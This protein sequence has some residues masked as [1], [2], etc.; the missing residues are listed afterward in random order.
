M[1][2]GTLVVP[3]PEAPRM[4]GL[5]HL[6]D[7]LLAEVRDRIQLT[8]GLRHEVADRLNSGP[9]EAVVGPDAELELLDQ[10]VVH[11]IGRPRGRTNVIATDEPGLGHA[12]SAR[13][14]ELDD[15]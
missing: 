13:L 12:R 9:F 1:T 2:D 7:R 3:E 10:D 8:L 4:Q 15:P 6:V 11:R 14:T 5:D